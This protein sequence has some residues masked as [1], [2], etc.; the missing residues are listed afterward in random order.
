MATRVLPSKQP[1]TPLRPINPGDVGFDP[2]FILELALKTAPVPD[3]CAAYNVDK[4]QFAALLAHPEFIRAYN[5]AVAEIQ[6][7]GV[8]FK[9]KCQ[10]LSEEF[11]TDIYTMIKDPSTPANTKADLMKHVNQLSGYVVKAVDQNP[12][13]GPGGVQIQINLGD[14]HGR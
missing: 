12:L 14:N 10:L 11:L 1:L 6:K 5:D 9:K 3:I 8:S 4:A 13:G 2:K 7:D